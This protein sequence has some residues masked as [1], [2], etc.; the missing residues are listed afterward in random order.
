MAE[1]V[2]IIIHKNLS[3]SIKTCHHTIILPARQAKILAIKLYS[4]KLNSK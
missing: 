2:E 4:V 3:T 1:F